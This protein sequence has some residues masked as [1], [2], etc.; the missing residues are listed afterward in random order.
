M[1]LRK[2][3]PHIHPQRC[4]ACGICGSVCS[5]GCLGVIDGT[6]MLVRPETCSSEGAC[7]DV[8]PEHAIRMRWMAI[9]GDP[10]VGRWRVTRAYVQR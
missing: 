10:S 9:D 4:K 8:C 7:V 2:W 1:E 5:H 3:V 6:G